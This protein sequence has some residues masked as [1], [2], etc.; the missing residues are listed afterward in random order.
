MPTKCQAMV[1]GLSPQT[2]LGSPEEE[3]NT[4]TKA[5]ANTSFLLPSSHAPNLCCWRLKID[6]CFGASDYKPICREIQL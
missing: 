3:K 5:K 6:Y 1:N 4:K 2:D